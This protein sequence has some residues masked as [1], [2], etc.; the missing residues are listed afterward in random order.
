MEW[1]QRMMET[2]A[3][4]WVREHTA[5]LG[6]IVTWALIAFRWLKTR[7]DLRQGNALLNAEVVFCFGRKEMGGKDGFHVRRRLRRH[8][9]DILR[10]HELLAVQMERA[11]GKTKEGDPFLVLPEHYREL[12]L[13][14]TETTVLERFRDEPEMAALGHRTLE[15]DLIF[16]WHYEKMK[17]R[18]AVRRLRVL[19][20]MRRYLNTLHLKKD[21]VFRNAEAGHVF[22]DLLRLREILAEGGE[23]A[24]SVGAF[25][26]VAADAGR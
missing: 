17:K 10:T 1:I 4:V 18:F 25:P 3:G 20:V 9:K 15:D 14:D 6:L 11:A 7:Y 12:I 2:S 24:A 8:V 26:I 13:D 23:R 21:V 16:V 22:A 5:L 19:V